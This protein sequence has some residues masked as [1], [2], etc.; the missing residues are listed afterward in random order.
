MSSVWTWSI[1]SSID[2]LVRYVIPA[3]HSV[4]YL[5][6]V[7]LLRGSEAREREGP[8]WFEPTVGVR[9]GLLAVSAIGLGWFLLHG[10]PGV[11]D[12]A[13]VSRRAA[14]TSSLGPTPYLAAIF[15]FVN[16][17]HYFMDN[18]IWRKDNPDT[19]YLRPAPLAPA[20]AVDT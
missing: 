1:Y 6:F 5:Y 19:R 7:G 10:V 13:L 17:H 4:Q 20:Q 12:G 14:V 9:L 2:P 11:L 16:I 15:T 8:P 18:V 3:L